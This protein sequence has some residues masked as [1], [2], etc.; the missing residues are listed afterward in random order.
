[1]PFSGLH[2]VMVWECGVVFWC[3]CCQASPLCYFS[4]FMI[5]SC[6]LVRPTSAVLKAGAHSV[7]LSLNSDSR[8]FL[9]ILPGSLQDPSGLACSNW[10][11]FPFLQHVLFLLI[12]SVR[13]ITQWPQPE[14][15]VTIDAHFSSLLPATRALACWPQNTLQTLLPGLVP[16][17]LLKYLSHQFCLGGCKKPQIS[18]TMCCL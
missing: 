5:H 10:R 6:S 13:G 2:G 11:A 17:V 8:C 4:F 18:P 15:V 7:L 3:Q 14:I 16:L 12:P 1:M 9:A